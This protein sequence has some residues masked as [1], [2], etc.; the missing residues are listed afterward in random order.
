VPAA[1]DRQIHHTTAMVATGIRDLHER[2]RQTGIER[3]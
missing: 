3:A 1:A 2:I